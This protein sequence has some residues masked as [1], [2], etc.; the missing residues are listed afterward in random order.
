M[1]LEQQLRRR[2]QYTHSRKP[3]LATLKQSMEKNKACLKRE[4]KKETLC[5]LVQRGI[6]EQN[7]LRRV[8][9][10]A[11]EGRRRKQQYVI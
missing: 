4:R 2:E 7:T 6:K 10:K 3:E 5:Y 11:E 8:E 1:I 9:R